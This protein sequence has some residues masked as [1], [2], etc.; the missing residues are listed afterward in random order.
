EALAEAAAIVAPL[1]RE[2]VQAIQQSDLLHADE[3]PWPEQGASSLWVFVT[4]HLW[5]AAQKAREGPPGVSL[6]P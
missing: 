6:R 3:T 5:K 4:S 2:L 1:E